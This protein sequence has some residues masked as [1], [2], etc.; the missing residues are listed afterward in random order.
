[1]KINLDLK[2]AY[3]SILQNKVQSV[4]SILGLGI[5]LGCI[6]LL[7]LLFLHE[8]SFN[9][10]IPDKDRLYR[11]ALGDNCRT[12]YPLAETAR[13][14]VPGIQDF[15]RIFQKNK[16]DIKTAEN[17]IILENNIACTDPALFKIWGIDFLIGH[18][19]K[20]HTEVAIS[21]KMATKYFNSNNPVNETIEARLNNEFVT[22]TICGNE[23]CQNLLHSMR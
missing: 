11:V 15:F 23:N 8:N 6:L 4:I 18:P 21:E 17:E 10:T 16:F 5:G 14:E 2:I 19:A 1:M 13:D 12:T 9:E 3:R 7:T 22:L 20:S